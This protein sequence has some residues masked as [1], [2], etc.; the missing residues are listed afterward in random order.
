MLCLLCCSLQ[1]GG[2][3]GW[4]AGATST[5]AALCPVS[6][7]PLDLRRICLQAWLLL[8]H[9]PFLQGYDR[10]WAARQQFGN[11]RTGACTLACMARNYLHQRQ[12]AL[13]VRGADAVHGCR[14][15]YAHAS[16]MALP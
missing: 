14:P 6:V 8:S 7:R 12:P 9:V 16:L 13:A 5:P 10:W 3:R 4:A 11:L 2:R 15:C 1:R